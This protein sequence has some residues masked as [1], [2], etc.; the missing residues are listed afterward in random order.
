M[1]QSYGGGMGAPQQLSPQSLRWQK[2]ATGRDIQ[3]KHNCCLR[4]R[5]MDRRNLGEQFLRYGGG[6]GYGPMGGGQSDPRYS[7]YGAP[8]PGGYGGVTVTFAFD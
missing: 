1:Q 6:G 2:V 5:G 3:F 7:P 8:A 4:Q